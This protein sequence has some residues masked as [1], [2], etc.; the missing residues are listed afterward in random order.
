MEWESKPEQVAYCAPYICP[1]HPLW[2]EH[3]RTDS[4]ECTVA[5]SPTIVEIRHAFTGRLVRP[6]TSF[7]FF[8]CLNCLRL[9]VQ[10]ITG[11][12]ISL[13]YDG[14]AIVSA[15]PQ[16]HFSPGVGS[17]SPSSDLVLPPDRRLHLSMRQGTFHVLYEVVIVA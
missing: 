5:I 15:P 17:G 2:L 7:S 13:T 3:A 11:A 6:R 1:F 10:F 4:S 9:Q 12:H 14:T 16:S 8:A